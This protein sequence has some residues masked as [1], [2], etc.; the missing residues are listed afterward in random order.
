M[1]NTENS[2]LTISK[3]VQV[4]YAVKLI[5]GS[6]II[7]LLKAVVE[8]NRLYIGFSI[9]TLVCGLV[10]TLGFLAF[11]AV[12]ISKGKNWARIIFVIFF[13]T[14][15]IPFIHSTLQAFSAS[16][17]SGTLSI[18][19]ATMQLVACILLFQHESNSWFSFKKEKKV[20]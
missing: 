18:I 7:G 19:Q 15:L 3:P 9:G 5:Y 12:T 1:N 13:V 2:N 14:G 16:F 11:F 20:V 4:D 8:Y 17:I 10:V 6:L